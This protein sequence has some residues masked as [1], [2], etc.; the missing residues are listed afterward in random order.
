MAVVS[1]AI[2]L[3]RLSDMEIIKYA[4]PTEALAPRTSLAV[5]MDVMSGGERRLK[6]GSISSSV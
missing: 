6:E 4:E 5:E 3:L 2:S 1:L